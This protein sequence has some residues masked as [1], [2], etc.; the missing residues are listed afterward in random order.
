[1]LDSSL[2][3]F[4]FFCHYLFCLFLVALLA[5]TLSSVMTNQTRNGLKANL[6]NHLSLVLKQVEFSK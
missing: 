4:T 6:K 5:L 2:K 3:Y 1:M